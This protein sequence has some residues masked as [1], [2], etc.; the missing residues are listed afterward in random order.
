MTVIRL[1][2]TTAARRKQRVLGT[3]ALMSATKVAAV[4]KT[5]APLAATEEIATKM[6]PLFAIV[7]AEIAPKSIATYA[8]ATGPEAA[9]KRGAKT[10]RVPLETVPHSI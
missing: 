7:T 1:H 8:R 5:A 3:S 6:T 2:I 4:K 9:T 10:N